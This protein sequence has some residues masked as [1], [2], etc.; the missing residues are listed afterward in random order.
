MRLLTYVM[1]GWIKI[2]MLVVAAGVVGFLILSGGGRGAYDFQAFYCAGA[3]VREHADPYR[4]QP[5]GACEHRV[6][7]GTYAAPARGVVLPAPQPGYDLAAFSEL[8]LLAFGAAKAVWG[9]LLG[10][11]IATAVYCVYRVS[12]LRPAIAGMAF[13]GSLVLPSFAFGEMFA[14]FAAAA[15]LAMFFAQRAQW[16][17]AGIAGA[18]TLVEPHLGLPVCV[19]LAVWQPSTRA[20]MSVCVAVLCAVSIG[21]LGLREN[22]EYLLNVLP[23]HALAE[24]SSDTQLSL[25]VILH[26]LHVPDAMALRAGAVAYVLFALC[27][28]AVAKALADRF[29]ERAF[30]VAVPAAFATLGGTFMHVTEIF[31]AVPLT[32]LLLARAPEHRTRLLCALVLLSVPWIAGIERGNAVAFALLCAIVVAVLLWEPQRARAIFALATAALTL[33]VLLAAPAWYAN[34]AAAHAPI[35][36]LTIDPAYAQASWQK[37]NEAALSSGS[38]PAWVLRAASWL[39]LLVLGSSVAAFSRRRAVNFPAAAQS[40]PSAR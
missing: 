31:A 23:L 8:A 7:D 13:A 16:T 25:S 24:I 14:F 35:S 30:L 1:T 29:T 10:V 36:A 5:L 26:G 9:A 39:G 6:T 12:G 11:A 37:W 19:C 27:G 3:A 33:G 22:T 20:A 21:A 2:A 34:A 4:A 28:I 18:A 40:T 17:C 38:A 32:L 15:C